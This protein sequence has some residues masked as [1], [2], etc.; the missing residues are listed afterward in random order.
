MVVYILS[1]VGTLLSI[2]LSFSPFKSI[3]KHGSTGNFEMIPHEFLI[4]N[5]ATRVQMLVYGIKK[6]I[7]SYIIPTIFSTTISFSMLL[8]YFSYRQKAVR[9][10]KWYIPSVLI[11]SYLIYLYIPEYYLSASFGTFNVL[12]YYCP[13]RRM[14]YNYKTSGRLNIDM[15]ILT[16]SLCNTSVWLT[17]GVLMN[18]WGVI[19]PNFLGLV[20][21][22]IQVGMLVLESLKVK[23]A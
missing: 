1:L 14:I 10:L 8:L 4:T 3:Q 2:S 23:T 20:L 19:I 22:L 6:W 9:F 5:H 17:Y 16:A 13:V 18:L 21:S 7:P 15:Y 11:L 12:L